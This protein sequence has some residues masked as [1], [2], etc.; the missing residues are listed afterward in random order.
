MLL[1]ENRDAINLDY[2]F[3]WI[4]RLNLSADFASIWNEAFPGEEPPV[5]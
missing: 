1:R 3:S 4:A 5:S 2:L